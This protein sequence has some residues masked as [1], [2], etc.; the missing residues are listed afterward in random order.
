M[1]ASTAFRDAFR[2]VVIDPSAPYASGVRAALPSVR[3][4]VD[5]WHLVRLAG[6]MVTEVRKRV[7]RERHGRTTDPC[8]GRKLSDWP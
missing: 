7:A 4:A 5:H 3:I 6:D 1:P 8:A 2:T